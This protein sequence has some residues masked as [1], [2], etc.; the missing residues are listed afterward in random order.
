MVWRI[1]HE[2]SAAS[3]F[4]R[5]RFVKKDGSFNKGC[6]SS[7][8]ALGISKVWKTME[9]IERWVI[10]NG[11]LSNF[12]KDKW[13]HPKSIL[14]EIQSSDLPPLATNAKVGDLIRDGL[15]IIAA[16]I[17]REI[18]RIQYEGKARK[19]VYSYE[20]IRQELT[21]CLGSSKGEFKAIPDILCCRKLGLHVENPKLLSPLEVHWCKPLSNWV[22]IN[23]DGSFLGNPGRARAGDI[24]HDSDGQVCNAFS[25]FLGIKKIYEAEFA[26][27]ME[28]ILLAK[29]MNARELWIESDSAAVVAVVQKHHIPWFAL[30]KWLFALPFL[31][32]IPWKITQCFREAITVADFLA[33]KAS[34]SGISDYSTSFPSHVLDDLKNDVIG[35]HR[36]RFL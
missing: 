21:L 31:E 1:K 13:W 4:L 29:N 27:A 8:I 3:S 7:S 20:Y 36:F 11:G 2:K 23:V 19:M 22:K 14:E 24:V 9:M 28:G 33:K 10:G 18:N 34:K 15:P 32:T 26:A 35:R 5:A 17:W 16:H 25:I 6:R 12:W 30:Q